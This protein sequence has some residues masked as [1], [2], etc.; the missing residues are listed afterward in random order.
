V[1]LVIASALLYPILFA[2]R[3]TLRSKESEG[4]RVI[5]LT[6]PPIASLPYKEEDGPFITSMLFTDAILISSSAL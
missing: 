3:E 1:K 4:D 5:K 6:T 2:W